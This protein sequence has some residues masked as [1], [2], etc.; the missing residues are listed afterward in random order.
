MVERWFLDGGFS[1]LKKCHSFEIYFWLDQFPHRTGSGLCPHKPTSRYQFVLNGQLGDLS[2][3]DTRQSERV[4]TLWSFPI[5]EM[6]SSRYLHDKPIALYFDEC[7][8][9]EASENASGRLVEYRPIRLS[10]LASDQ[11]VRH[12]TRERYMRTPPPRAA[13]RQRRQRPPDRAA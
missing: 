1:A 11:G 3:I 4:R 12:A 6:K 7:I 5:S 10:M 9:D 2:P 8:D 13:L